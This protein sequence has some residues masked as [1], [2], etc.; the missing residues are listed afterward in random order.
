MEWGEETDST[1]ELPDVLKCQ[2]WATAGNSFDINY[3]VFDQYEEVCTG[4]L[5]GK[6]RCDKVVAAKNLDVQSCQTGT[7]TLH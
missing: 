3:F 5:S 7:Q 1:N 2:M 6:R 4:Y